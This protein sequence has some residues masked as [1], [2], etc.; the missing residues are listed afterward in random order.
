LALAVGAAVIAA[1]CGGSSSGGKQAGGKKLT[2]TIVMMSA[3]ESNETSAYQTIF[4][5]LINAKVGYKAQVESIPDFETQFQIRAKSGTLQVAAAPQPG[6]LPKLADAGQIVSLED[7]GL[8]I[9]ALNNLVGK[10]FMDLALY[11]GKHWGVPTNINLK[12]MV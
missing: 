9:N 8:D 2:G 12:S 1:G 6:A 3:G 4:D 10:S 11:K 7:L 5:S